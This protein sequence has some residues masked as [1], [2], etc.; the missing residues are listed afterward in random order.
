MPAKGAAAESS[1]LH[2]PQAVERAAHEHAARTPRLPVAG[3]VAAHEQRLHRLTVVQAT[4]QV[5]GST[6]KP[7][8]FF[9]KYG[10]FMNAVAA[11]GSAKQSTC[12]SAE[13][14]SG[15]SK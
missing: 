2:D 6:R 9:A 14:P 5:V 13:L 11:S 8:G 4:S 10:P 15:S 3:D 7:I 1:H 12:S